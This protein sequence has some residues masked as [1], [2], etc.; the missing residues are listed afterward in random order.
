MDTEGEIMFEFVWPWVFVFIPLSI[1]LPF[2]LPKARLQESTYAMRVPFFEHLLTL[3]T[4]SAVSVS[5]PLWQRLGVFTVWIF[6]VLAGARPVHI[7]PGVPIKEKA[8]ALMLAVDLSGSMQTRDMREGGLTWTRLDTVKQVASEFIRARS[9]DRLGLVLFG[10]QPY[11][12]TPLTFDRNTVAKMLQTST[13]GIAGEQTALG[14]AI[15]LSL[16][17]LAHVKAEEKVL[18]LLT[19]GRNNAGIMEPTKAAQLAKLMHVRIYT[20]GLGGEAQ[21]LR[22]PFGIMMSVSDGGP[23]HDTLQKIARMTG[24]QYF[25]AQYTEDLRKVYQQLDKLEPADVKE[26]VYHPRTEFYP[27]FLSFALLLSMALVFLV[28]RER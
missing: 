27:Y 1:V 22:G 24:G 23:D 15:G 20:I 8:R 25:R 19:D 28:Q 7:G 17:R 11:L 9:G 18:I 3:S 5:R 10:S 14:D 16:K 21:K 13:A 12:R 2:M 4:Q 26:R 6:L